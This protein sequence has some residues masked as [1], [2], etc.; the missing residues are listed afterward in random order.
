[1]L[2]DEKI[3]ITGP[4][5]QIAKPLAAFLAADN[6]VWG[7]ARFADPGSRAEVEAI[8]VTTVACRHR[9]RRPVGAAHDFTYA[10]HL[11]AYR[12]PGDD[13]AEAMRVNAD[14]TGF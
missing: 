13:F 12:E 5:G 14:G 11:A 1:M 6:E 8:G 2:H 9:Q 3:L 7:V 4:A 10:L